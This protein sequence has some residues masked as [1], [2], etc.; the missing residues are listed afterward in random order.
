MIGGKITD[1]KGEPVV[2]G[3]KLSPSNYQP[4]PETA[5][6][7][8]KVQQDYQVAYTLQ[9]RPFDE[10]DSISLL[11]RARLD[12][13]TF[14]AFVGAKYLPVHK[15]WRWQGRKN[16]ARNKL[17]GI[18]A[19]LLSG[20]L[21]PYVM[22]SN[23]H[24]EP[25]KMTARVMRILVEEHLR[26][27]GYEMKFMFMVLSALVNPAVFVKV[28]YVEAFQRVKQ[29]GLDGKVQIVDVLD[30]VISGLGLHIVPIDQLMLADFYT[31]D[32]QRQPYLI[33][34]RRI[35][36]D[37]ARKIYKGRF[38][39]KS[40]NTDLFD[41]VQAGQ[42]RVVLAGQEN[43]TLYDVD[44]TEADPN[45]VQE[46]TAYYR[47]EDLQV[48]FV[49]GVFMGDE[50]DIYNSNP[51]EHRRMS[52]AGKTPITIPVY[53]FAKSGFEPMDPSG[54]FAYY[55]SG[56]NKEYWD[57][58]SLNQLHAMIQDGTA[59]DV[60]KPVFLSGVGKMDSTVMVPG[61]TVGMPPGASVTPYSIGPNLQ[62]A[63]QY[64]GELEKNIA[65]STQDKP[66]S[67]DLTQPNVAAAAVQQAQAN[68]RKM[69]GVFGVLVASLVTQVG[70]L[71]MDIE[72]Q[73]TS[74][75]ELDATVPEAIS[76][77]YKTILAKGKEKGKKVTN[78]IIFSD[79]LIGRT[80]TPAEQ[81]EMEWELFERA[82][83]HASEQRVFMVNPYLFART[84]YAMW[85]D[86]DEIMDNSIGGKEQRNLIAFQMMSNPLVQPF[87]NME[88]V[89]DDFVIDQYSD[90]DPDRY[91][92]IGGADNNA[93][94]NSM[95]GQPP[96]PGGAPQGQPAM[97]PPPQGIVA[98][99]QAQPSPYS[100][101]VASQ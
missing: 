3:K 12:Q 57:D 81:E 84:K 25:D 97:Q 30:E 60:I 63:Y 6:L 49:G 21:F 4:Q 88:N 96:Q 92:K 74:V 32:L 79:A 72:V 11:D 38:F 80:L 64:L 18:L 45:Y 48:T 40:D 41:F 73:Y 67:G 52:F 22:A 14:G 23:Q 87:V 83:G 8:A 28:E 69:L 53:P 82:G 99:P 61:A 37:E 15:R 17:I 50:Q 55:K 54:R 20:M 70:E 19:D 1:E 47:D 34:I 68:A 101:P 62:M 78:K 9:H 33:Y 13:Q 46:I 44:W 71:V 100:L 77:K 5:K 59:L 10:F 31:F 86:P 94:L 65:D 91:K 7:F 39:Q 75:G 98:P 51:F 2:N 35:S 29:R 85:V 27:A 93:M 26:K 66:P 90:G 24:D 36:Y 43:Q 76:M 58:K 95:M 16:T 56:A 89:V 42:T